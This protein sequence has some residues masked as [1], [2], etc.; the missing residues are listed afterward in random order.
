MYPYP[1]INAH[2]RPIAPINTSNYTYHELA[3]P[4]LADKVYPPPPP[5]PPP[6][7]T[8]PSPA[9]AEPAFRTFQE[10][11]TY[12]ATRRTLSPSDN[13]ILMGRGVTTNRHRKCDAEFCV[14][15]PC[16]D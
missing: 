16:L 3:P 5:P 2:G 7:P 15:L 4:P 10:Q 14:A 6:P 9:R 1:Y 12:D 11:L 8:P 13:D